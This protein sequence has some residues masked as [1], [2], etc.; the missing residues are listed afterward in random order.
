MSRK[1]D[2]FF[3]TAIA[4]NK[5]FGANRNLLNISRDFYTTERTGKRLF[6][7]MRVIQHAG[8]EKNKISGHPLLYYQFIQKLE[9]L[10]TKRI[11]LT[12]MSAK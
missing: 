10:L 8:S 2:G 3:N 7:D 5:V 4:M 1:L 12:G 9:Y 6:I 11:S